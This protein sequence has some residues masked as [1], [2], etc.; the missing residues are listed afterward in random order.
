MKSGVPNFKGAKSS[1][2]VGGVPKGRTWQRVAVEV[3]DKTATAYLN[4]RKIVS[5]TTQY[6]SGG[7]YGAIVANGYK[8]TAY[9][10]N[11]YVRQLTGKA[12]EYQVHKT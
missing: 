3:K 8:N 12:T 5:F 1:T 10:K 4:N 7:K 2:C 6:P 11:L 9:F